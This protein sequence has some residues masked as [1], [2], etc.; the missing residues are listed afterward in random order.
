MSNQECVDALNAIKGHIEAYHFNSAANSIEFARKELLNG[1]PK[2][3]IRAINKLEVRNNK[4]RSSAVEH[5][6]DWRISFDGERWPLVSLDGEV[7]GK[8]ITRQNAMKAGEAL[9]G[10][11]DPYL[12]A[13]IPFPPRGA[14]LVENQEGLI[15]FIIGKPRKTSLAKKVNTELSS[16]KNLLGL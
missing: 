15:D 8:Y 2:D 5:R 12:P 11:T 3:F 13:P 10:Y 14:L 4:L 9:C 16:V 1:A 7:F 6:F